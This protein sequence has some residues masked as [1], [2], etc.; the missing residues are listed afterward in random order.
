VLYAKNHKQAYIPGMDPFEEQFGPKRFDRIRKSWAH[1]FRWEILPHLPIDRLR[2]HYSEDRGRPSK[3]LY[4]TVGAILLQQLHDL[5]DEEAV[6]RFMFDMRWHYALGITSTDD[7]HSYISPRTLWG[8]RALMSELG[9]EKEIFDSVTGK[10]VSLYNVD[11]SLQ[12]LDSTHLCSNMKRLGRVS[13][14]VKTIQCFLRNLKRHYEQDYL[15]LDDELRERYMGRRAD[16]AFASIRANDSRR[17]LQE[18]AEDVRR[19]VARFHDNDAVGGMSSYKKLVRLFN[20]QCVVRNSEGAPVEITDETG[21][22][23][24]R[25]ARE[26]SGEAMQNP[27]DPDAGYD[28]HKGQGYQVQIMESC[29]ESPEDEG[30]SLITHAQVE[31]ACCHDSAAVVPAVEASAENGMAPERLLADT[32]YGSDANIEALDARGVELIAPAPG[33]GGEPEKIGLHQF[34]IDDEGAV[35]SCPAGHAPQQ[36]K[37]GR[38]GGLVVL[39]ALATCMGCALRERC[40]VQAGKKGFYL[41]CSAKALRLAMR[42]RHEQSAEFARLYA[43]RAGIEA[44][45]SMAKRKFGLGRLRVRGMKA[46]RFA[47]TLKLLAVNIHRTVV[48]G[49][50]QNDPK[51][52]DGGGN[53]SI[54]AHFH[55]WRL[56]SHAFLASLTGRIGPFAGKMV[57]SPRPIWAPAGAL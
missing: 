14:F 57:R 32:A 2:S 36:C 15:A 34:E 56:A 3:E 45:H 20:E 53:G 24:P 26:I 13:L 37:P 44:T 16:R 19:L 21:S 27:S 8:M 1:L 18:L 43:M 52:P 5:T 22:A 17:K 12:R 41:R 23:A 46:V 10:L 11:T 30:L 51:R 42:R 38:N 35:R 40:R 28:G 48:F 6:E 25:A 55:R 4:A 33:S 31:P 54:W 39:F 29:A 49:N 9:M 7:F 50:R 47:V